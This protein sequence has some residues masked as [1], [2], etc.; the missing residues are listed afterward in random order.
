M[1]TFKGKVI[2]DK[3]EKTASVLIE[4][5]Y[6]HPKYGKILHRSRKLH[7]HNEIGAKMGDFVKVVSIRPLSKTVNFKITE[8]IREEKT[9]TK[10]K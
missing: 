4:S 5:V 3:M 8:V 2:S 10:K 7:C 1:K 6:R 9:E